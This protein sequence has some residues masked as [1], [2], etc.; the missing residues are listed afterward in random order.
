MTMTG[1]SRGAPVHDTRKNKTKTKSNPAIAL[2]AATT[3]II[4]IHHHHHRN[5]EL[6]FSW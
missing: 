4:I 5:N 3:T 1:E 6:T 2:A